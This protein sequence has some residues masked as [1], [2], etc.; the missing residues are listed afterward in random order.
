MTHLHIRHQTR[1]LYSSPIHENI[2]EVRLSPREG[3]RQHCHD[4][5]LTVTPNAEIFSHTDAWGN[6]VHH[7]NIP[8]PHT[9]LEISSEAQVSLQMTDN[10]PEVL[11]HSTWDEIDAVAQRDHWHFVH[12]SQFVHQTDLLRALAT[13]LNLSRANDPLTTLRHI[14]SGLFEK[15]NYDQEQTKVDSPID[16]AL[17]ARGGVCQDFSHIMLALVRGMGIPCRY[18]SGYL[19]RD[20]SAESRE[21]SV[22]DESHAWVEAWLP[23]LGWTGFDPTNDLV[24]QNRHVCVAVGRDYADVPPTRGVFTGNVTTALSVGVKIREVD[25]PVVEESAE[26]LPLLAW[27]PAPARSDSMWQAQQQQQ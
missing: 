17:K 24:V 14:N 22:E 16:V 6:I 20:F 12:N 19:V 13:E 11:P 21:R 10:L 1:F 4:F 25:A 5:S 15:F 27:Q 3:D 23:T 8:S 7:F 9:R 18:V 2:M 26:L